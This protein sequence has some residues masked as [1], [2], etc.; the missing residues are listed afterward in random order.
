MEY[1]E[2][3]QG[4]KV[5]NPM[6]LMG[7]DSQRYTY[8]MAEKDFEALEKLKVAY[9]S[10]REYEEICD[11]LLQPTF[12]VSDGLKKLLGLYEKKIQFKGVQIFPT[13]RESRQYPIYWVP[14][15][16]EI[17][18]IHREADKGDN[19]M[20]TRLVLDER[21][22]G[23]RPIFRLPNL[24]EYKVIVS[25]PVAESILRRRFYGVGFQKVEVR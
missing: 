9:F 4:K 15:F 18:C 24:I 8:T 1:F 23:N 16:P 20:I 7:L 10:G 6:Q 3:S 13:A 19:G 2:M 21:K 5:E 14:R 25:M 12:L 22:I 11:I 17:D